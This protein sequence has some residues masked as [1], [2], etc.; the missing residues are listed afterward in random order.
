MVF[1]RWRWP[2]PGIINTLFARFSTYLYQI[3]AIKTVSYESALPTCN[4]E[5]RNDDGQN[6]QL[7]RDRH[8]SSCFQS[9]IKI[10]TSCPGKYTR[11]VCS[12]SELQ[13]EGKIVNADTIS[14]WCQ[15]LYMATCSSS[16]EFFSPTLIL[17]T[18]LRITVR[19]V[20]LT[21]SNLSKQEKPW[22]GDHIV[23]TDAK[24]FPPT[25]FYS[26]VLSIQL[27]TL[28]NRDMHDFSSSRSYLP[29]AAHSRA[30]NR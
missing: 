24:E 27:S 4:T 26:M 3:I 7:L 1:S 11:G 20:V 8:A 14:A 16:G 30:P 9:K 22:Q 21:Q 18:R 19:H 17:A 23:V 13:T 15:P 6:R 10:R 5:H 25:T 29:D 2:T 12:S 28:N